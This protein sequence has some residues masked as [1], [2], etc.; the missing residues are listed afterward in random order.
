M[1]GCI[2]FSG[3]KDELGDDENIISLFNA[4][5]VNKHLNF[6][7]FHKIKGQISKLYFFIKLI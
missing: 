1:V 7:R 3:K 2:I 5:K 4:L 6:K